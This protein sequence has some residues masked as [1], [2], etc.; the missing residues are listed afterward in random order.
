MGP[1]AKKIA[2]PSIAT[3][4]KRFTSRDHDDDFEGCWGGTTGVSCFPHGKGAVE[5]SKN[6]ESKDTEEQLAF[7]VIFL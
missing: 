2:E 1:K 7:T 3:R 6:R 5:A 4:Q